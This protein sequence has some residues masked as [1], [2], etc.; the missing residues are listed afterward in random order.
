MD[1]VPHPMPRPAVASELASFI[2]RAPTSTDSAP[3]LANDALR[4]I[5]NH[6]GM[7]VA[8]ISEFTSTERSFRYVDA[9][10]AQCPVEVGDSGPLED[11]YC[12]RVVDGRLP[13]LIRDAGAHPAAAELPVT[14]A[15]AG[16]PT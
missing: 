11:S 15:F 3:R 2:D 7:D 5:R 8:F 14:A 10:A 6:L 1:R 13:E 9:E 4:A 12:Q 16:R